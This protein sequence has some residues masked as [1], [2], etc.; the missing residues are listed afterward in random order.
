[1]SNW[2]FS[3]V[4]RIGSSS[5][6]DWGAVKKVHWRWGQ[7]PR[8][9]GGRL[10]DLADLSEYDFDYESFLIDADYHG[11]S[12]DNKWR[13]AMR[14]QRVPTRLHE[15]EAQAL[16]GKGP[17]EMEAIFKTFKDARDGKHALSV[18]PARLGPYAEERVMKVLQA[19]KD[20]LKAGRDATTTLRD[21]APAGFLQERMEHIC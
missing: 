5:E 8:F 11:E 20:A 7:D 16:Y 4:P 1:M 12:E 21:D 9:P 3:T 14:V 2:A 15:A 18:E 10:R 19:E 13:K 17:K 6:K